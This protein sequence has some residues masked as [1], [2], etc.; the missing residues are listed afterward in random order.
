MHPWRDID[1]RASLILISIMAFFVSSLAG[2]AGG[3]AVNADAERCRE[4]RFADTGWTDVRLTTAIA[5]YLFEQLHY[6]PK[7]TLLSL[8]VAL[9]SLANNDVDIFMGNWMPSQSSDVAPYAA[10]ARVEV[11]VKNLDGARYAL[12]VPEYAYDAGLKRFSDLERFNH[13]LGGRIYGVEPGNDGNR[14][15]ASMLS[16]PEYAGFTLIQ[17]SETGMLLTV[18]RAIERREWIVFLA[19]APHPMNSEFSIRY[20]DGGDAFF[21]AGGGRASVYTLVR[22]NF[23]QDCPNASRLLKNLVFSI[24]IENRGMGYVL[25]D[26]LAPRDSALRLMRHLQG[27]QIGAWL[28]GVTTLDGRPGLAAVQESLAASGATTKSTYKIP[29]G[30]LV[31]GA[32]QAF[33]GQFSVGLRV[34]VARLDGGLTSL[35]KSLE[36][37][38]PWLVIL[39]LTSLILLWRRSFVLSLATLLGLALIDNLGLFRPTLQTLVLVLVSATMSFLLGVPVGIV[40]AK[41]A[42]FYRLLSPVLDGLQTIPTFVFL[43]PA[44]MLFGLGIVPGVLATIAFAIVVPIRMTVLG[45]HNVPTAIREAA[46][47]LGATAWLKLIHVELPHARKELAAALTQC[48]MLSLSMVVIAALVGAEGLGTAVIYALSAVDLEKGFEAGLAIVIVAML[49][50]RTLRPT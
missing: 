24:D 2:H 42:R 45:L 10:S 39:V 30:R 16:E 1:S 12:A 34:L 46:D 9:S 28:A 49:L 44:L 33:T 21:G 43:I 37:V 14:S 29:I 3:A 48:I 25:R 50:D 31:D 19:W 32:V 4:L 41:N 20:L 7:I 11:L 18:K 23:E 27:D 47:A 6:K 5:A 15:I 36:A 35:I 13:K 22:R 26:K 40:A 8:P 38:H 17:S